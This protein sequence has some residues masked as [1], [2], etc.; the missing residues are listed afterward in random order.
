MLQ[1]NALTCSGFFL[2]CEKQNETPEQSSNRAQTTHN[3]RPGSFLPY[4]IL[5]WAGRDPWRCS[6]TL[7]PLPAPSPSV[8]PMGT[9]VQP[10]P[11]HLGIVWGIFFHSIPLEAFPHQQHPEAAEMLCPGLR[12]APGGADRTLWYL[13][14]A[15][16]GLLTI[17][18]CFSARGHFWVL[19]IFSGYCTVI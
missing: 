9:P 3:V 13:E 11:S 19:A 4:R 7:C 14:P 8:P 10:V 15:E 6:P 5:L 1:G 2:R 12:G 16:W 18:S 17:N